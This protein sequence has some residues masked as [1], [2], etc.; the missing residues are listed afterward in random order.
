M[1]REYALSLEILGVFRILFALTA[2]IIVGYPHGMWMHQI[3]D[4]FYRP[5]SLNMMYFFFSEIPPYWFLFLLSWMPSV[6]LVL[7]MFG[8]RTKVSAFGFAICLIAIA[9]FKGSLGKIDHGILFPLT[10]VIM[11]FSGWDKA[12]SLNSKNEKNRSKANGLAPFVLALVLGFAFFT[13]G[14]S[15]L[16]GG[17]LS[18]EKVGVLHHYF[19]SYEVWE[20]RQFLAPIFQDYKSY[21]FWKFLDYSTVVFELL[22]LIAVINKKVF[23][24]FIF[25]AL[26]FHTMVFLMLNIT[27]T[28]IF[29]AYAVFLPWR[30]ILFRLKKFAILKKLNSLISHHNLIFVL[31]FISSLYAFMLVSYEKEYIISLFSILL[32]PFDIDYRIFHTILV[33]VISWITIGWY[34]ME[35]VK[36]LK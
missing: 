5:Q 18:L 15:K 28:S 11:A 30:F 25:I 6:F 20:R 33:Y 21:Y 27:I 34:F 29:L 1:F 4:Y 19:G 22:F 26:V 16:A 2:L 3:P 9:G 13:A 8:Y 35:K 36:D 12:M 23:Q 32:F 14:Y 24:I 31:L 10:S 7:I 17:W